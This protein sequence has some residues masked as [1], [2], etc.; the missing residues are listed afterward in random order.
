MVLALLESLQRERKAQYNHK[1]RL[2]RVPVEQLSPEEQQEIIQVDNS[3]ANINRS[4]DNVKEAVNECELKSRLLRNKRD[5][6]R[7]NPRK[8]HSEEA[9]IAQAAFD[10]FHRTDKE[11][12][13]RESMSQPPQQQPT[14]GPPTPMQSPP[15]LQQQQAVVPVQATTLTPNHMSILLNWPPEQANA[16]LRNAAIYCAAE[17]NRNATEGNRHLLAQLAGQGSNATPMAGTQGT[18]MQATPVQGT[19]GTPMQGSVP[20]TA[21]PTHKPRALFNT[22]GPAAASSNQGPFELDGWSAD[23]DKGGALLRHFFLSAG[24]CPNF[25]YLVIRFFAFVHRTMPAVL[26]SFLKA[27]ENK[28]HLDALHGWFHQQHWNTTASGPGDLVEEV[29]AS[30]LE[31]TDKYLQ[32][33]QRVDYRLLNENNQFV[34]LVHVTITDINET[35][36]LFTIKDDS[37]S[38]RVAE[39]DRLEPFLQCNHSNTTGG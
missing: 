5:K 8:K 14:P 6:L 27:P 11:S 2:V 3:I 23:P 19:Q 34:N 4:M 22:N 21:V 16:F 29:I 31:A 36:L 1:R 26:E 13:V 15:F 37:G 38:E 9:R 7:R 28:P 39:L 32:V 10:D 30:I 20:G 35:G 17:G 33:G 12:Y 24:S 25:T 18:P